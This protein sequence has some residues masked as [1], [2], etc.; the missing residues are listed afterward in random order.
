MHFNVDIQGSCI[1]GNRRG[2]NKS[3]EK[4]YVEERQNERAQKYIIFLLVKC[5]F[6]KRKNFISPGDVPGQY[7][8]RRI[9][10]SIPRKCF[11]LIQGTD[12]E[13][14]ASENLTENGV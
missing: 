12:L 9:R 14:S 3:M 2:W 7:S 1:I 4:Y 11:S 6:Q 8:A 5:S 13:H 10:S